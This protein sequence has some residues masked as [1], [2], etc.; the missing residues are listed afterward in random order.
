M[1][2]GILLGGFILIAYMHERVHQIIFE[3]YDIESHIE[4]FSEFPDVAT[5]TEFFPTGKCNETCIALN[6][7]N[8]IVGYHLIPFF[9]IIGLGIFFLVLIFEN[10][11]NCLIDL[12][13]EVKKNEDVN[14]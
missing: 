11:M 7:M 5:K 14:L 1:M 12:I 8:E 2:M 4:W 3:H 10:I 9:M 13:K 6:N